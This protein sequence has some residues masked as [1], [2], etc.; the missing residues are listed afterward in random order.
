METV[1]LLGPVF[2]ILQLGPK[3]VFTLQDAWWSSLHLILLPDGAETSP[4]WGFAEILQ[5]PLTGSAG[6]ASF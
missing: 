4:W 2:L 5:G 1:L 6:W 3:L